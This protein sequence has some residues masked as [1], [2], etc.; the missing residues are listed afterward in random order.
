MKNEQSIQ[1]YVDGKSEQIIRADDG[2]FSII[3][4]STFLSGNH[5]IFDHYL[6]LAPGKY[7]RI[8]QRGE[9]LNPKKLK[10][11][12]EFKNT[13]HL[14]IKNEDRRLYLRFINFVL[15]NAILKV[16]KCI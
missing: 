7:V 5:S 12:G 16:V 8:L 2:E 14:Y 10:E 3:K 11:H 9:D 4:T 1:I 15:S 13:E 6:K